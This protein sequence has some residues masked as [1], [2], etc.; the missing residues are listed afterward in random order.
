M[1][2]ISLLLGLLFGLYMLLWLWPWQHDATLYSPILSEVGDEE[3]VSG[4]VARCERLL[5]G[6][7]TPLVQTLDEGQW[8]GA[9]QTAAVDAQNTALNAGASGYFSRDCDGYEALLTPESL[10]TLTLEKLY[11]LVPERVSSLA[12]GRLCTGQSWYFLCPMPLSRQNDCR[13][14]DSVLLLLG[15]DEYPAEI[16]RVGMAEDGE[17]LLILRCKSRLA[18]VCSLRQ[19]TATV[20]F[21]A[22]T[23]LLVPKSALRLLDGKT[24][25]YVRQCGLRRFKE[26][27]VLGYQEEFAL[28]AL[29]TSST[30]A[31][32]QEDQIIP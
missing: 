2:L 19:V 13:V 12:Y 18:E 16:F 9:G 31:L 28:L 23:G 29:D 20:R 7:G 1:R 3:T 10:R 24:G 14:G 32:R 27:T 4:F 26:V 15:Q 30:K 22:Q 17:F 11:A 21:G 25:V 8:V 6:D 5:F